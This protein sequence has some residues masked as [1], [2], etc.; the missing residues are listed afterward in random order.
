MDCS[1][2]LKDLRRLTEKPLELIR[3][4][5][6]GQIQNKYPE[7]RSLLLYKDVGHS[8]T[9]NKQKLEAT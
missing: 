2:Y 4:L 3:C 8:I 5:S 1:P 7:I 9:Y 6:K